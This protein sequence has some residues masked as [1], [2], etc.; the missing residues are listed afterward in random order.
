MTAKNTKPLK[1]KADKLFSQI[2]RERGACERCGKGPDQAQLQCAHIIS[3]RYNA[4]RWDEENCLCLC[5][6]CHFWA[7][8]QPIAFGLWV[9]EK[10]GQAKATELR[11]Q[12]QAYAGRVSRIDYEELI[13]RLT[14]RLAEL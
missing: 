5:G 10:I 1:A 13:A 8:Q 2:I 6:G 3:R 12:A 9:I 7:H 11:D 4:T 14:E